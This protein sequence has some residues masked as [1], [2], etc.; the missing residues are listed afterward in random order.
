[1]S[2]SSSEED[3]LQNPLPTSNRVTM[4]MGGMDPQHSTLRSILDTAKRNHQALISRMDEEKAVREKEIK[5]NQ[6][7]RRNLERQNAETL[8]SLKKIERQ[9]AELKEALLDLREHLAFTSD[10]APTP[11]PDSADQPKRH[12]RKSNRISQ[13]AK[14]Q[15]FPT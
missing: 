2:S 1:M 3:L 5:E 15:L 13:K 9:N 8:K 11:G 14:N 10:N 6:M 12:I 7:A 4:G